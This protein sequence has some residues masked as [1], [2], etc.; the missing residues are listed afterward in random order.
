ML[1]RG[2]ARWPVRLAP[3]DPLPRTKCRH[4]SARA[5]EL[6]RQFATAALHFTSSSQAPFPFHFVPTVANYRDSQKFRARPKLK[7]SRGREAPPIGR[8]AIWPRDFVRPGHQQ[9]GARL[10]LS[11]QYAREAS[12]GQ[13]ASNISGDGPVFTALRRLLL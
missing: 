2:Q 11:K 5:R 9:Y 7:D 12:P 4:G 13:D 10:R 6:T 1:G 3:P 8:S